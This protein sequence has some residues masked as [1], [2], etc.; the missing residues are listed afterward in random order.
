MASTI[1]MVASIAAGA[2]LSMATVQFMEDNDI[3]SPE[4]EDD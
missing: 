3:W 2:Y 1:V 4:E